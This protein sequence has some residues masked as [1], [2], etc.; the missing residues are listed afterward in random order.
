MTSTYSAQ[1]NE[2]TAQFVAVCLGGVA[3]WGGGTFQSKGVG[4]GCG[5]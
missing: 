2:V 5:L 4:K 1:G 3:V